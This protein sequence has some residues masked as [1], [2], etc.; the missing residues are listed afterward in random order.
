MRRLR[1]STSDR[2]SDWP[3]PPATPGC[4]APRVC[5][6]RSH[7][8]LC[9]VIAAAYIP[10]LAQLHNLI[11]CSPCAILW[12]PVFSVAHQRSRFDSG[13]REWLLHATP[14]FILEL[15]DPAS[16]QSR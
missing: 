8:V 1:R 13:V 14:P 2:P 3:M 16:M 10:G 4:E 7:C 5:S 15:S 6:K 11:S 9:C 12:L